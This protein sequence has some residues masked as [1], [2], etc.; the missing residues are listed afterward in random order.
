[1]SL[2]IGDPE[3]LQKPSR[4]LAAA[5]LALLYFPFKNMGPIDPKTR[6]CSSDKSST[7]VRKCLT[8]ATQ[9][10]RSYCVLYKLTAE[11]LWK[12]IM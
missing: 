3:I 9:A 7:S 2:L 4:L 1:M 8:A 5:I 6:R 10:K 11:I 12:H